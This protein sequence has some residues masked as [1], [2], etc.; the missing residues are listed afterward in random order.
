[1]DMG[2]VLER[3]QSRRARIA[4]FSRV[5]LWPYQEEQEVLEVID[6]LFAYRYH[7][8]PK[9][10]GICDTKIREKIALGEIPQPVAISDSGYA[11]AWFGWQ[12]IAW[13]K[14]RVAAPLRKRSTT[15]P[16]HTGTRKK[17]KAVAR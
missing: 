7:L 12:I 10:F 6:P 17:K 14:A 5:L 2:R 1:M 9:I 3:A 13:Q 8:G 11:K 15:P 4:V 16:V